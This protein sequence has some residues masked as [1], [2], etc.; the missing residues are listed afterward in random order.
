MTN[1]E[2]SHR[3]D[4]EQARM[5]WQNP[6]VILN[7]I[8]LKPGMTFVDIGCGQGFFTI[9]AAKIVGNS[10]KVYASDI[11]QTNINKLREKVN[12]A[13]LT[14]V[15]L[16]TAKAED[17]KLCDACADI[18]FFG[19]VLHDFENPLKVLA[20]AHSILKPTGKLVNLDWKKESMEIGPPLYIRFSERKAKQLLEASGFKVQLTEKSGLY[21]YI[22]ITTLG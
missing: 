17:L 22:V 12:N 20:N 3:L 1:R 4:D 14:N 18:I 16:E 19:I 15:N 2:S 5:T 11:N 8:G 7:E 10:G 13:G 6:E 21:H 9:P